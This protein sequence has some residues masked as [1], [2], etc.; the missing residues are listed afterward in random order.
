MEKF[1]ADLADL[2]E[3]DEV[4]P[5]DVLV[6]FEN[7][8]SLTVLSLITMVDADFDVTLHA[9]D[10]RAFKTVAELYEGVLARKAR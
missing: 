1:Y 8:D 5:G 3:V 2:L 9:Q 10:I 6:D 4:A 7:W